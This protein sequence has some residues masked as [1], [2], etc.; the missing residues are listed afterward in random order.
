[1]LAFRDDLGVMVGNGAT[2]ER[3]PD[4]GLWLPPWLRDVTEVD[5]REQPPASAARAPR[6]RVKR[7][8]D[9]QVLTCVEAP[10]V[11]VYI[12]RGVSVTAP[13]ARAAAPGSIFL[14]G[15]ARGEPFLDPKREVY[16]LDHH[17]GC[18]RAFTLATCE[19][20]MVLLR[21]GLDLRKRDWTV[22]ANDPDLDTVLAIW[23]LLNHIRLRE[24][25][26]ARERA[27][28]LVRLQG[29]T[30]AQ[31][32]EL[33]ELCGFPPALLAEVRGWMATLRQ[34]EIDIK[35]RRRW[36][37]VDLLE[38]TAGVLDAVDAMVYPP[39]ELQRV[40]EV[41]ELER[42]EIAN[43]AIA[44]VCR[45]R[46]GIYEVERQLRRLHGRRL[47]VVALQTDAKTYS[48]RQVDPY[49]PATLEDVYAHLNLV[50]SAV[51]GPRSPNRWGGS[52]E[53]G[54]SPRASGTRVSPEQIARACQQA[55]ATPT[56][57]RRLMRIGDA[58][59]RNSALLLA[60]LGWAFVLP[61]LA[62]RG[63]AF[64]RMVLP[65]AG[66]FPVLL[67]LFAGGLLARRGSRIRGLYG[68]RRPTGF[69]WLALFPVAVGG[70]LAGG[71]WMP[72]GPLPTLGAQVP[73]WGWLA[74]ALLLPTGAEFAFRGLLLGSVVTALPM[75]GWGT[76]L[77]FSWPAFLSATLYWIWGLLLAHPGLA[78]I[79]PP[80][81]S[82]EIPVAAAQ[83]GPVVFGIA[84]GM[85]R[86]RSGSIVAALLF[87]WLSIAAVLAASL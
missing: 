58:V 67:A 11:K 35:A 43:G 33:Q 26:E 62:E 60:A 87:H 55:F 63:G 59:A 80:V 32:L 10:T 66:L 6:Y 52:A 23:V 8:A 65:A 34:R 22:Y 12:R 77:G 78:F 75:R 39:A 68:L 49:L 74:A 7:H 51:A 24:S 47:G 69:G 85:A 13:A 45:S 28:P 27:M 18:I 3:L 29:V 83:L 2:A 38:Y 17:E 14:D 41:E 56:L 21:K 9:G 50:D 86:E 72:P 42:V 20:A 1:M 76:R 64:D 15:A 70:A 79:Q 40:E 37:D 19:Q 48:L 71:V 61:V 81:G 36:R 54:G 4:D 16:N 25:S 73:D 84:A 57:I 46:A 30:D 5:C 31:G 82:A 44:I 53:I